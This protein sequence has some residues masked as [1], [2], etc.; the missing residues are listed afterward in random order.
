M[1][2]HLKIFLVLIIGFVFRDTVA[3]IC[4]QLYDRRSGGWI[5]VNK[6]VVNANGR[7]FAVILGWNPP[8]ITVTKG[9]LMATHRHLSG[10]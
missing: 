10:G 4:R 2:R 9:K 5:H 6:L 3:W 8:L 1:A 7:K